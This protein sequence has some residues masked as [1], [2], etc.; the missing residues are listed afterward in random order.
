MTSAS[1]S[2]EAFNHLDHFY[3]GLIPK[4]ELSSDPN[5]HYI[6]VCTYGGMEF[7]R[8]MTLGEAME[9]ALRN[10]STMN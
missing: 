7:Y 5:S 6:W 9:I 1:L 4:T 2:L 3:S 10:K 8:P